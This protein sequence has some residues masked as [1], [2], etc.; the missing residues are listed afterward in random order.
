MCMFMLFLATELKAQIVMGETF[1]GGTLSQIDGDKAYGY[2][3]IG[4]HGG[5]GV[6]VPTYVKENFS[7]DAS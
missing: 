2:K 5:I 4:I 7:I 1:L 3:R 6:I